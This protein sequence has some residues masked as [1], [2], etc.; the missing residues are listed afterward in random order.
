MTEKNEL[1]EYKATADAYVEGNLYKADEV[2]T[3]DK[4]FGSTWIPLNAA[5]K[6]KAKEADKERRE[7][8]KAAG[9]DVDVEA[10]VSAAV[11]KLRAE[12]AD[13]ITKLQAR[14]EA[15]EAKISAGDDAAL[16]ALADEAK[17]KD[18][19]IADLKARLKAFEPF[20]R[21]GDQKPGGSNKTK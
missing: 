9:G 3:T 7:E 5:A 20:D 1:P 4:P 16:D 15:A 21:D 13:E 12:H 17:A 14:A 8:L 11:S 19:E 6:A 2:F 10:A 18:A